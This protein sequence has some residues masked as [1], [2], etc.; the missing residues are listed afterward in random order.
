MP[1]DEGD[2]MFSESK[3]KMPPEYRE[4]GIRCFKN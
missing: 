1:E 2:R 3:T 4:E